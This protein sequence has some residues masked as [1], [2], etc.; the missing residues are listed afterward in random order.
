MSS[1]LNWGLSSLLL[2]M[3]CTM[4][5]HIAAAERD[6]TWGGYLASTFPKCSA[7]SPLQTQLAWVRLDFSCD[8]AVA[9]RV[10][11]VPRIQALEQV[12]I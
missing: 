11:G 4:Q 9:I 6:E 1:Q 2:T 10:G 5:P 12:Y 7:H 3:L 8:Y